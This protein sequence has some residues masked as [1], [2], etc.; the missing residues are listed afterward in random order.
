MDGSSAAGLGQ[1]TALGMGAR[2]DNARLGGQAK[3]GA[4]P[5]AL[6]TKSALDTECAVSAL[7]YSCFVKVF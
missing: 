5:S 6:S 3:G 1:I 2:D 7:V 4:D